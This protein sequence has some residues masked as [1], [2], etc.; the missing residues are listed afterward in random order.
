MTAANQP[1]TS[2]ERTALCRARKGAG[3]LLAD[4][5]EVPA[6]AAEKLIEAGWA[7]PE[8]VADR[9]RLS[10]IVSDILDCWARGTLSPPR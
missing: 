6:R 4:G 2:K 5:V 9:K 7:S 3:V 1:M 8:E 10:G